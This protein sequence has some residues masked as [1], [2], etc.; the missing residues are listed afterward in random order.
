MNYLS[1]PM[2]E[3]IT[4]LKE[5]CKNN[6]FEIPK[7]AKHSY[8]GIPGEKHH[9]STKQLLRE[10]NLG[11]KLSQETKKKQS[12]ANKGKTPWNKG[13]PNYESQKQKISNTLSKEW[14]IIYP[15]GKEVLI[16]NLTKFCNENN[17]FQ[18]NMIKV[19]QEKQSHHKG[20]TCRPAEGISLLPVPK[21]GR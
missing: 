7:D 8:G 16:K 15:D 5:W 17:L 20:F 19:S 12:D 10:I 18:S 3:F 9:E 4:Q 13:V 11:K 6:P 1:D 21:L 14:I 2:D